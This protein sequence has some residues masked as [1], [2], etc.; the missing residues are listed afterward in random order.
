MSKQKSKE[1]EL[2]RTI[3][4][5]IQTE[6]LKT[7]LL[8]QLDWYDTKAQYNRYCY[9]ILRTLSVLLPGIVAAFSLFTFLGGEKIIAAVSGLISLLSAFLSHLLDQYRFYESWMR[10]RSASETLK[11]E[12]FLCLGECDPYCGNQHERECQLSARVEEI[13]RKEVTDWQKLRKEQSKR[14]DSDT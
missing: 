11:S 13:V 6:T 8:Y 3:Q 5:S 2:L 12:I 10:Y 1:H 9:N 14:A 4:K 7:R